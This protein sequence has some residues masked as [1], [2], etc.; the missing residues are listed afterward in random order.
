MENVSALLGRGLGDVLGELASSGYDAE[1]D[2]IPASH[3]GAPHQRDRIFIVATDTDTDSAQRQGNRSPERTQS[4]L[5][6]A[7]NNGSAG[8][9][10]NTDSDSDSDSESI[11]A[12]NGKVA[13][14][15]GDAGVAPAWPAPPEF[16]GMDDGIRNR[17]ERLRT[18]GNAVVP[19]V[20]EV[21]GR[22]IVSRGIAKG[23]GDR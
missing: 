18:L 20:A 5:A 11:I 16:R 17:L 9:T 12:R 1:W 6:D 19:Q 2:C 15:Q 22:L 3:V 4:Q 14:L 10:R 21:I 23:E 7:G 13:R 8:T